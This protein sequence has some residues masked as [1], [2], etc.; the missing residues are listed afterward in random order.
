MIRLRDLNWANAVTIIRV[1]LI[2]VV[3]VCYYSELPASNFWAALL[4]AIASISDWLDGY[5]AR[6]LDLASDFGAFLDPIADKL[7]VVVVLI[8]LVA[9]HSSLLIATIV[10][11][12]REILISGLREWMSTKG[13][14]DLVTVGFS[15]KLKTTIQMIAIVALL[16]GDIDRPQWLW[17]L[18]LFG[19][20][21]AALISVY[22]M[23]IYFKNAWETLQGP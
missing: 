3:A 13:R 9:A 18:G 23:V 14:R 8:M 1:I 22:S 10:L 7:L 20:Y 11:I 4:F 17:Q 16:L 19:I 6:K 12:S 5:L 2:P 21:L 15:G